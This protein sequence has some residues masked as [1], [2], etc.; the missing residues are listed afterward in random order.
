MFETPE[1]QGFGLWVKTF[2]NIVHL[3]LN[4]EE[5]KNIKSKDN[6]QMQKLSHWNIKWLYGNWELPSKDPKDNQKDK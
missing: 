1:I 4:Y 2:G 3:H 6:T 5:R